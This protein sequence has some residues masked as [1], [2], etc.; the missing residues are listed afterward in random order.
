M[1]AALLVLSLDGCASWFS[2]S[3]AKAPDDAMAAPAPKPVYAVGDSYLYEDNGNLVREQVMGF[4]GSHVIWFN[5]RGM[6]WTTNPDIVSPPLAWSAD[7]RLGPGSQH[8]F[9]DPGA[10]FPLQ[11]G[12]SVKFLVAGSSENLPDGWQADNDCA[13]KS[14]ES[15]KVKAGT[16]AAFRIDCRRGEVTE[17]LFYAPMVENYVLRLRARAGADPHER[18]ELVDFQYAAIPERAGSQQMADAAATGDFHPTEP[19]GAHAGPAQTAAASMPAPSDLGARLT[20][21]EAAVAKLEKQNMAMAPTAAAMAP[22]PSGRQPARL[23]PQQAAHGAAPAAHGAAP[24]AHEAAAQPMEAKTA[25]ASASAGGE[26]FGVHLA[27]YRSVAV[28]QDG[29]TKLARSFPDL[30]GHADHRTTE[31]D[32]G[33]GRGVFVRLLAGPYAERAEAT[34]LCRELQAKQLF[35]RVVSLGPA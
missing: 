3:T 30:L 17:S 20:R 33:D 35:C 12:K 27:S 19:A 9:G 16:F 29:W 2:R 26:R 10:L 8:L 21:L 18:K 13:V 25:S 11:P 23:S 7:A 31:F 24:A 22:T 1:L 15:V 28:A 32:P 5:D 34:K 4:N 14:Q 6:S